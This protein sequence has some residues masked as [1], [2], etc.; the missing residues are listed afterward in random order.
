MPAGWGSC[1]YQENNFFTK[2][3]VLAFTSVRE[4]MSEKKTDL[5]ALI[6]TF[7]FSLKYAMLAYKRGCFKSS[8]PDIFCKKG[9]LRYS[10]SQKN[11]CGRFCCFSDQLVKKI[12]AQ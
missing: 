3:V 1:E 7:P 6:L 10:F 12:I 4:N 8:R 5:T 2:M 9:V 11:P